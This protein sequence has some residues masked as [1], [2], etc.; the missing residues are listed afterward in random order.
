MIKLSIFSG[1]NMRNKNNKK[2]VKSKNT[3]RFSSLFTKDNPS[4]KPRSGKYIVA[5]DGKKIKNKKRVL[6]RKSVV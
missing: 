4:Y 5:K 2:R 1:G 6:D 3:N